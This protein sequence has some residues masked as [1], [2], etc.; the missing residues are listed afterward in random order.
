MKLLRASAALLPAVFLLTALVFLVAHR[1]G[2]PAL[3]YFPF[4][5]DVAA[6]RVPGSPELA[7]LAQSAVLF[8]VPYALWLLLLAL[9]AA[10]ERGAFGA[11]PAPRPSDFGRTFRAT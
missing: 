5:A 8:A 11:P 7:F 10:A 3:T 6:R 9:V 4:P 1:P 2:D